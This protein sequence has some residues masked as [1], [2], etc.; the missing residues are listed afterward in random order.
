M[1]LI[2]SQ[3]SCASLE[4][5]WRKKEEPLPS[6]RPS[7]EPG[8]DSRTYQEDGQHDRHRDHQG[9]SSA[10]S[11]VEEAHSDRSNENG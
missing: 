5:G 9:N 8:V 7:V 1:G 10:K 2:E 6:S 4:H 11:A 3:S